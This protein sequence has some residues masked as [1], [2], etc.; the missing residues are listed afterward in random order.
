MVRRVVSIGAVGLMLAACGGGTQ[1]DLQDAID[2][3]N[4]ARSS[5][6]LETLERGGPISTCRVHPDTGRPD[7][8]A[9]TAVTK[10]GSWL[11]AVW[12]PDRAVRSEDVTTG[13]SYSGEFGANAE[14]QLRLQGR[15]CKVSPASG[16]I[17]LD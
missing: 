6:V 7:Y 2:H 3:F 14:E 13:S 16:T 5:A 12:N 10:S 8:L 9:V 11:Q 4:A 1:D 15:P 17:S